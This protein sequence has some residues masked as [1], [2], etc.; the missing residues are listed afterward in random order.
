MKAVCMDFEGNRKGLRVQSQGKN[1]GGKKALQFRGKK[2]PGYQLG[3]DF[4]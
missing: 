1:P 2:Y 3:L 4:L